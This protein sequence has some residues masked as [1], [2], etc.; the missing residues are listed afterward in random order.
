MPSTR[1]LCACSSRRDTAPGAF[2][3][4]APSSPWLAGERDQIA[5][6]LAEMA[7]ETNVITLLRV[8]STNTAAP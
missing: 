8:P 6:D 4:A 2:A 7:D 3:L 5:R 1:A